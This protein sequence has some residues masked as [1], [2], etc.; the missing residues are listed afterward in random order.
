MDNKKQIRYIT[1][2]KKYISTMYG[3]DISEIELA[4]LW[5][6]RLAVLYRERHSF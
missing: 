3:R 2:Y 5:C 4:T 1:R 6:K